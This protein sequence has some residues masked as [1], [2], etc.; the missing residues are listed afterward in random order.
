MPSASNVQTDLNI[1]FTF[2]GAPGTRR[3]IMGTNRKID[4]VAGCLGCRHLGQCGIV[5]YCLNPFGQLCFD[6]RHKLVQLNVGKPRVQ[7]PG[8]T[9]GPE[10]KEGRGVELNL[11][12]AA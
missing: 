5:L 6:T 3:V 11:A 10:G 4:H 7:P 2:F 12:K 8:P 1:V 9:K